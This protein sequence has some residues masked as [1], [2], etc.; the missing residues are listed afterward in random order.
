MIRPNV[1]RARWPHRD[2]KLERVYLHPP[3]LVWRALTERDVLAEWLMPNDFVAEVGHR[4]TMRTDPAPG[5]DGV[6]HLEVLALDPPVHMR[7]SWRGGPL[8]TE[9]GFR[10]VPEFVMGR[11]ATRLV[12]EHTGFAGVPAVLVSFIMGSGWAGM[13]KKRLPRVFDALADGAP[14][15]HSG[16]ATGTAEMRKTGWHRLS[17]LFRPALGKTPP[18]G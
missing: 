18:P 6:V 1:S 8:D 10:L 2:I 16:A 17:T 15:R 14:T 13:M 12:L 11:E 7:W 4:F 3:A 9:V 5:F